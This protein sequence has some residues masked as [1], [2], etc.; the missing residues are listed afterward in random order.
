MSRAY[1]FLNGV[2]E[3]PA[4]HWPQAPAP[5][6]LV[7]AADGGAAH[8]LALGWP[9]HVL[10]GDFDSL[11][12]G[13]VASLTAGGAEVRRHPVDKDETDFELALGLAREKGYDEVE[14]LA[15]LGGRW[16]MSLGNLLV[17]AAWAGCRV[18]FRQ[19]PWALRLL[20]GPA[21]TWEDGAPGDTVSLL[22][23]GGDA[24]GVTLTGCRWPLAGETLRLGLTR[25]LSNKM[26][27][28]GLHLG[29]EA[30]LLILAHQYQ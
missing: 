7:V 12:P 30:G 29:L 19:G 10:V 11:A 1:I 14:V 20:A 27:A 6:D 17:P 23:V 24:R 8:A 18:A 28:P 22:P 2:F 9:V 21:E 3:R 25:G 13:T 4:R 5:G 15:A 16:D 26:T